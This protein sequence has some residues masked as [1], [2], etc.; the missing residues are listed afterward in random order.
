M[1]SRLT[2]LEH[3]HKHTRIVTL[4]ENRTIFIVQRLS[5]TFHDGVHLPQMQFVLHIYNAEN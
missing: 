5:F 1:A 2:T 4:W 3:A